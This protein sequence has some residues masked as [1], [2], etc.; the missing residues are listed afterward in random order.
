M[1]QLVSFQRQNIVLLW[2]MSQDRFSRS[3]Q[4]IY[5]ERDS[6]SIRVSRARGKTKRGRLLRRET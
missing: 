5:P 2:G 6:N 3:K 1:R 4:Q